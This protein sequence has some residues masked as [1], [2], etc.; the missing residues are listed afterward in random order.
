MLSAT[1]HCANRGRAKGKGS[2]RRNW[3]TG[4]GPARA[5]MARSGTVSV[6]GF[7]DRDAD[8]IKPKACQPAGMMKRQ[9]G[10]Q[11]PTSSIVG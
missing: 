7:V 3:D 9:Q 6:N 2:E 5:E 1:R 10:Q 11:R 8:Y 4:G